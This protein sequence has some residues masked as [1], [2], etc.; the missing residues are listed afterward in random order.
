[1]GSH[2]S[3][4]LF[5]VSSNV[6]DE[7]EKFLKNGYYHGELA[8]TMVLALSNALQVAIVVLSSISNHPVIHI[9]PRHIANP[10]WSW[11]L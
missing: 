10:I 9:V 6:R 4:K 5:L 11:T 2:I 8:D 1:M 7:A 3:V